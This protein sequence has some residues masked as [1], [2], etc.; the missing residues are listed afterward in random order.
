ML[1]SAWAAKMQEAP[2]LGVVSQ[3]SRSRCGG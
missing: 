1:I 2:S 3:L